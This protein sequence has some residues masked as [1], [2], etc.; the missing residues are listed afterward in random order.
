LYGNRNFDEANT[1]TLPKNCGTPPNQIVCPADVPIVNPTINTSNNR[2]SSTG[3][4]YDA[5]GNTTNDPEGRKFIYDAENKQTEVR[6][7]YNT[8][9]GQYYFDGDGRRV[10]KIVPSTG[11]TTVFVYD[12][13]SNLVAEYS[14]QLSQT[15]QVSYIT[16]DHLGSPRVKTDQNGAVIARN[17][18]H[19]Y[20]E[21][22][23]TSQRTTALCYKPDDVRQKF[24]GHLKDEESWLDFV[25]ARMYANHLGRFTS[26]DSVGPDLKNPQTLNKY[27]YSL[28]NPMRYVD[29]NGKYEEDVHRELTAVLAYAAGFTREQGQ[30]IGRANQWVDDNPETNP[31]VITNVRARRDYHFT[32]GDQRDRLWGDFEHYVRNGSNGDAYSALGTYL[33]AYQ[34]S[35]S[36]E[37]FN[38]VT[39]QVASGFRQGLLTSWNVFWSEVRK[40]DKTSFDLEK[41]ERMAE[42]TFRTLFL[43][44]Y[45]MKAK[46]AKFGTF[47]APISYDIIRSSVAAWLRATNVRDKAK[48]LDEIYRKIEVERKRLE[49]EAKA[50]ARQ[51]LRH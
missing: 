51:Q 35:Y 47:A 50:K 6:D 27:Q 39:G 10:K 8:V 44:M 38:P 49:E 21:D 9:I 18:Y 15:Q 11:E 33:H 13:A 45:Q 36:H 20:G 22:L 5:A 46:E 41:A 3:W 14:T 43:A 25:E 19:P 40:V 26:V 23:V 4:Q 17:D 34:D 1:T 16:P 24:A 12:A 2:L 30:I 28:N 32:I 42:G 31:E 48:Y 29:K 37:G 7:Q